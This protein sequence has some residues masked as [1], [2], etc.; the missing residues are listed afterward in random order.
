MMLYVDSGNQIKLIMSIIA[1]QV[2]AQQLIS[3]TEG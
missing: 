2:S 3:S 1:T